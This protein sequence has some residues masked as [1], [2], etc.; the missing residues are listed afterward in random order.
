[1]KAIAS[2]DINVGASGSRSVA[3]TTVGTSERSPADRLQPA[4]STI[5]GARRPR[6]ACEVPA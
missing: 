3:R 4:S 5:A 6:E 1:M 2:R